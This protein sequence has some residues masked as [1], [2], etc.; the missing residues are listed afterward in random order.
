MTALSC[1]VFVGSCSTARFTGDWWLIGF[2]SSRA[3]FTLCLWWLLSFLL[4]SMET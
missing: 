3:W 2:K 4:C 1:D